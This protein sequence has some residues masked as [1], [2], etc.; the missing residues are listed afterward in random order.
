MQI[1]NDEQLVK[2]HSKMLEETAASISR[3][4]SALLG[5]IEKPE[6]GF[7]PRT[8]T[9]L[10]KLESF[11][12]SSSRVNWLIIAAVITAVVG[13]VFGALKG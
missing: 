6:D 11:K 2:V 4:E 10:A 5:T 13:L 1:H 8:N 12:A 7:I 3:I 9:R